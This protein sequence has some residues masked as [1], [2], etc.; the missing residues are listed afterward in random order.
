M[1]FEIGV[2]ISVI[3]HE[4]GLY[5][6]TLSLKDPKGVFPGQLTKGKQSSKLVIN[7]LGLL[8]TR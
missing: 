2:D 7:G 5:H 6:K 3:M 4:C 8:M 1:F